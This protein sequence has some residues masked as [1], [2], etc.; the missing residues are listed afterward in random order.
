MDIEV[1]Y[2]IPAFVKEASAEQFDTTRSDAVVVDGL[3]IDNKAAAWKASA[4]IRKKAMSGESVDASVASRV[5]TACDLFGIADDDFQLNDIPGDHVIVKTASEG[6]EFVICDN[7][8]FNTAVSSIIKER[9]KHPVSFVRKCA[10]ELLDVQKRNGYTVSKDAQTFLIKVAGTAYVDGDACRNEIKKRI[11]YAYNRGL[12]KEAEVLRKL[13]SLC[14][15]M[16]DDGSML[17]NAI[18]DAV[19]MFDQDTG[20]INKLASEDM[21]LPEQVTYLDDVEGLRKKANER[22]DLGHGA[23]IRKASLMNYENMERMSKW[24]SEI[25][26]DLPSYSDCNDVIE[27]VK[28]LSPSLKQEF[29]TT[30]SI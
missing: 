14:G 24:A 25:G 15:S 17:T 16:T 6:V 23:S 18:I 28:G 26:R 2:K 3:R 12:D 21:K 5:K 4:V 19:D 27:F 8:Q 7:D 20:L 13:A 22:I 30:F 9:T 1:V 10:S 29:V 11:T